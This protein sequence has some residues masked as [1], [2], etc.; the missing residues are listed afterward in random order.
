M[1]PDGTPVHKEIRI[2]KSKMPTLSKEFQ[3]ISDLLGDKKGSIR[4]FR[5]PNNIHVLEY[6]DYWAVHWD[7]GD[8]RRIDGALVHI[9]ADAPEVGLALIAATIAGKNKYDETKSV[10][11]AVVESVLTGLFTY[12]G[13][14]VTKEIM[15]WILSFFGEES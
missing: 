5:G 9:F 6:K 11:E 3:E 8:P 13:I 4:Q 12:G 15:N 7:W 10:G 1:I 14:V 2:P